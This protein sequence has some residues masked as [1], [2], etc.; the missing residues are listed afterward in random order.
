M[1]LIVIDKMVEDK[2]MFR[3][4]SGFESSTFLATRGQLIE[5]QKTLAIMIGDMK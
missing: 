3:V 4:V 5:M 2:R 1:T